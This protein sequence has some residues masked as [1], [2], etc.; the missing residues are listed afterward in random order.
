MM[1][2]KVSGRLS[3]LQP[4]IVLADELPKSQKTGRQAELVV[5]QAFVDWN[6]NV[7]HDQIDI[8]YDLC[9]TPIT[10]STTAFTF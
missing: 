1:C 10:R 7:G 2:P 8:G 5:E 4:F 3:S 6:W 9:I